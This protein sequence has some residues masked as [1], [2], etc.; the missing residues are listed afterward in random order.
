MQLR[1]NE[2]S[3][4][5]SPS[6]SSGPW[7]IGAESLSKWATKI[8][9]PTTTQRHRKLVSTNRILVKWTRRKEAPPKSP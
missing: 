4:W 7:G 5:Q 9:A 3:T 8:R 2:E 1:C 6:E